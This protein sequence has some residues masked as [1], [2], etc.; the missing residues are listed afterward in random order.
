MVPEHFIKVDRVPLTPTGKSDRKALAKLAAST[1]EAEEYV[2]P[3]TETEK[4]LAEVWKKTL[5]VQQVG[6]TNNFFNIGG[7]SIKILSLLY[8]IN[9]EFNRNFKVEDLYE[10]ETI[11]KF[12][13]LLNTK[14]KKSI[15]DEVDESE[16]VVAEM[17]ELKKRFLDRIEKIGGKID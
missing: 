7:D 16:E 13:L 1:V 14:D 6:V 8:T 15:K 11:A 10:N 12:A 17:E 5:G 9:R 3:R 2:E 4:K